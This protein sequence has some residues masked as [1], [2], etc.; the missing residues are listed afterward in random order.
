MV[1]GKVCGITSLEDAL[2]AVEAGAY[3]L[4]FVF[5]S[6]PRQIDPETA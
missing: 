3:A 5:A 4:G 1:R 6:S 2:V